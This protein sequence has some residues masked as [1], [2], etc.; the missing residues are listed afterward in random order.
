MANR[1][2]WLKRGE[3]GITLVATCMESDNTPV[4]LTDWTAVLVATEPGSSESVISGV[5]NVDPDQVTNK[6]KVRY[7]FTEE[8]VDIAAGDYDLEITIT[9][10]GGNIR[11]FPKTDGDVFGTLHVMESKTPD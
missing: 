3:V 5:M 9:D 11:K 2:F 10:E 4:D 6:G 7:V 8:D 1:R